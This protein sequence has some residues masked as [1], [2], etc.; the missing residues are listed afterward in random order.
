MITVLNINWGALWTT[1]CTCR[2][3]IF[4]FFFRFRAPWKEF[5]QI[6]SNVCLKIVTLIKSKRKNCEFDRGINFPFKLAISKVVHA[7]C[8]HVRKRVATASMAFEAFVAKF[9]VRSFFR[10]LGQGSFRLNE[11][12]NLWSWI[13]QPDI[14][15]GGGSWRE[16]WQMDRVPFCPAFH[17]FFPF[18]LPLFLPVSF[19]EDYRGWPRVLFLRT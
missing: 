14:L 9:P 18:L 10:H 13:D 2:I 19:W 1:V 11:H 3:F 4:F 16:S 17:H 6:E 5:K 12:D 15:G 7:F 8:A